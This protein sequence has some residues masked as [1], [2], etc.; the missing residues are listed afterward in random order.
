VPHSRPRG[1]EVDLVT[2]LHTPTGA[3]LRRFQSPKSVLALAAAATLAALSAPAA[4][5]E[6]WS[7]AGGNGNWSTNT[8]WVG[9]V[10]PASGTTTALTFTGFTQTNTTQ[11]I[12]NPFVVNTMLFDNGSGFFTIG[13]SQLHFDGTTPTLTYNSSSGTQID[14][15]VNLA[16]NTAININ[17]FGNIYLTGPISGAGGIAVGGSGG[18]VVFQGAASNTYAGLTTVGSN[19]ALYLNKGVGAIAVA[20]DLDL[21]ANSSANTLASNQI[22]DTATV[23]VRSNAQLNIGGT[24]AHTETIATLALEGGY[25]QAPNGAAIGIATAV[26]QAIGQ[27]SSIYANLAPVG[28]RPFVVA[29]GFNQED[30][31]VYG[32]FTTGAFDKQGNGTM[33]ISSTGNVFTATPVVSAGTLVIYNNAIPGNLTNNANVTYVAYSNFTYAGSMG[34]S[35]NVTKVGFS[36]LTLTGA[37]AYTGTTFV[38]QG[39]LL[40]GAGERLADASTLHVLPSGSFDLGGFTETVA[41]FVLDGG[42][43]AAGGTLAATAYDVRNGTLGADL[44][45]G[46][47]LTKSTYNLVTLTGTNSYT[48][49]TFVTQGSL[50]GTTTSLQGTVTVSASATLQISQAT[51]G[52][53]NA[54]VGG[55]GNLFKDGA[56]VATLGQAS[57]YTGTAFINQGTLKLGAAGA[58]PAGSGVDV[59]TGATLDLDGFDA[60]VGALGGGGTVTLG[61]GAATLTVQSGY[62]PGGVTGAGDVVKSGPAFLSVSGTGFT[63]TGETR[64]TGG[65]LQ[66]SLP[67]LLPNAGTVRVQT[68]GTLSHQTETIGTLFLHDGTVNGTTLTAGAFNVENGAIGSTLAGPGAL[69][70]STAGTVDLYQP[71]TYAG[72]AAVQAGT[73]VIHTIGALPGTTLNQSLIRFDNTFGPFNDA[74]TGPGA[75]EMIGSFVTYA[76]TTNTYAGG[77]TLDQ[78]TLQAQA[79]AIPG[80]VALL[81]G[82]IDFTQPAPGTYAGQITGTG[83][84]F[85]P[86]G[87]TKFGPGDLTLTGN[88]SYTGGTSVGQ[89]TLAVGHNSAL[90]TG[91]LLLQSGTAVRA[92]GGPRTLANVLQVNGA[93][94]FS[95][96]DN[97]TF[98]NTALFTLGNGQTLT[99]TNTATTTIGAKFSGQAGSLLHAQAGNFTIGD[100]TSFIGFAT[101]GTL[102]IDA[103]ATMTLRSAGFASLPALT[104]LTG[105][106]LAAANGVALGP[107]QTVTGAGAVNAKIAAQTGSIINATGNLSVGLAT[108]V[109]GYFSDGELYTHAN[110]VTLNDLNEAVLGSYT[111][112]GDGAGPGTLNAPNKSLLNPGRNVVG[113][114]TVIGDFKNNGYVKGEGPTL[115]DLLDFLG[116]VTGAGAFDGN[117]MFTGGYSPGNSP[118]SVTLN[119]ATFAPTNTLTMELGGLLPGSQYDVLNFTGTGNLNGALNVQLINAFNPAL[120]NAF[121]ILNGT[122]TS[123]FTS[124]SLPALSP[125]LAWDTSNLYTTGVIQVNA[126]PEPAA[127]GALA[128]AATTLLTRRR[129]RRS[130]P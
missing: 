124:M 25:V 92:A 38:D 44:A 102:Q 108:H 97:L 63:H 8:N 100:P 93:V 91:I 115:P 84:G 64:V 61:A 126:V 18:T 114:G 117:V 89:G 123:A 69:T 68:G 70:K 39:T 10:A 7:G 37:N 109:A 105:G 86:Y 88:N 13:G 6:T 15:A 72:G 27:Q 16:V 22:A 53:L 119:N 26:T 127:L 40:L 120:G 59:A 116:L 35:G 55:A 113:Y 42:T 33:S 45:G 34:G 103:G 28:L 54:A 52:T 118:A 76:T 11:N 41:T 94:T 85:V 122:T 104:T 130:T 62:F 101:A 82:S 30:L 2:L 58:I 87:V 125:G 67:E 80:N 74:I 46:G 121:D 66:L 107:S 112:I 3:H 24:S 21:N 78:S 90:G 17:S 65:T 19:K 51:N 81:N 23:T 50:V 129:R 111:E 99:N 36:T 29:D 95:G 75:V 4:R 77:T 48:G 71:N 14:A 43:V 106:T 56:G 79:A 96:S 47:T 128:L 32:N 110:T 60:T 5:A 83:G 20:G 73:L 57:T 12:A 98:S 49:G 9:N 31:V 1:E